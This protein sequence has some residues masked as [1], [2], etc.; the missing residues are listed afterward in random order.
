[1][2]ARYIVIEMQTNTDGTIGN[3][4]TSFDA[5]EQG[6]AQAEA[7]YHQVLAAAALSAKP[8][9]AC[10]LMTAEGFLLESKCYR[11]EVSAG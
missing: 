7:K 11:H 5:T 3:Q 1:M 8:I 9:H 10:V 2:D 6:K 4:V